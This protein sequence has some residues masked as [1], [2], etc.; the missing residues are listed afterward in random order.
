MGTIKKFVKFLHRVF[1]IKTIV[2]SCI[3]KNAVGVITSFGGTDDGESFF[4]NK[5]KLIR[6]I[7]EYKR[8]GYEVTIKTFDNHDVA[9]IENRY[10]ITVCSKGSTGHLLELPSCD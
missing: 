2:I 1:K 7:I 8:E 9:I 3:S 10:L 5:N 4:L 6:R